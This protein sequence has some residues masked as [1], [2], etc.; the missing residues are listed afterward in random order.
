M[1]ERNQ[2]PL[3]AQMMSWGTVSAPLL[4]LNYRV[5]CS[6]NFCMC[7]CVVSLLDHVLSCRNCSWLRCELAC[8]WCCLYVVDRCVSSCG[9]LTFVRLAFAASPHAPSQPC[10]VFACWLC[11]QCGYAVR[12]PYFSPCR[13]NI[14]LLCL[15]HRAGCAS[16]Y[17]TTTGKF[18]TLYITAILCYK[19]AV[20]TLRG[21]RAVKGAVGNLS[22]YTPKCKAN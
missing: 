22:R 3:S 11:L 12:A 19:V 8:R 6:D 10:C 7:H 17:F 1:S 20:Y 14:S 16:L 13:C 2:N 15:M 21:I 4:P 9:C 18:L 5:R